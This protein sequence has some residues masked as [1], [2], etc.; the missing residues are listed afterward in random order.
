LS[1]LLLLLIHLVK[2]N[3]II[4]RL[5]CRRL[6]LLLLLT[7]VNLLVEVWLLL[8]LGLRVEARLREPTEHV[9]VIIGRLLLRSWLLEVIEHLSGLVCVAKVRHESSPRH[10]LLGHLLL[11]VQATEKRI[12]LLLRDG[13]GI[14]TEASN[15]VIEWVS[16]C[17]V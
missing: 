7:K 9:E 13:L 14:H 8:L 6:E 10:L 11:H 1:L 17:H 15:I 3:H 2:V 5:C 12:V 4:V 16:W